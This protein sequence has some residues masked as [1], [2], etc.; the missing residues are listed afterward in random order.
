MNVVHEV[1]R[2]IKGI[3]QQPAVIEPPEKSQGQRLAENDQPFPWGLVRPDEAEAITRR[4][5]GTASASGG[6][7]I[8]NPWQCLTEDRVA[9]LAETV[10]GLGRASNG[11]SELDSTLW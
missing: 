2:R 6:A 4:I 5:S 7:V 8:L 9:E 3:G 11:L 1:L 10:K